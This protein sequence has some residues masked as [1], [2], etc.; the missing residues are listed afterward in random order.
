MDSI[1]MQTYSD[2]ELVLVDD[3]SP[4]CCPQICDEYASTDKRIKVIHKENGG[5]SDA[6]NCGLKVATG[7]Y[8]LACPV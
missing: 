2:W 4:D 7:E 8:V 5:L 6:R 1:L 3:G